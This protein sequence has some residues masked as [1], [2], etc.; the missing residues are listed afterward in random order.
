VDTLVDLLDRAADRYSARPA[1]GLRGDDDSTV[2]WSYTELRRRARIAAW[3]LRALG[4]E[5]GDRILTWSPS[6]PELPA[7]YFGATWAGL[8]L[9][10]LDLRMAPDAIER[11]VAGELGGRRLRA[12]VS[13]SRRGL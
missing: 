6:T 4:L 3:R 8:V 7:V 9:V 12:A 5:A 2:A 10:P 1:L 11:I 13:T